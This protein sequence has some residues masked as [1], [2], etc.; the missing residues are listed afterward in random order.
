MMD[1]W[2]ERCVLAEPAPALGSI[3]KCLG[4]SQIEGHYQ[5][6]VVGLHITFMQ[7]RGFH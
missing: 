2:M 1:G 6:L 5:I 3:G 7:I 4:A